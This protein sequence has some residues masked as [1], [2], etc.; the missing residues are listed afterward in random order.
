MWRGYSRL[1]G[2]DEE[3]T[4][5]PASFRYRYQD[6]LRELVEVKTKGLATTPRA[7]AEPGKVINL[8]EALERSL[9]GDADPEPKKAAA[10]RPTRGRR[11]SLAEGKRRCCYPYQGVA[12]RR[13]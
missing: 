9:A 2:V 12:G 6:A 7:V 10:S 5:D 1:M 13:T 11:P 4:L 8:M 3:G